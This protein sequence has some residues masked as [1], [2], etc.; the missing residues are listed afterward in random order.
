MEI[1]PSFHGWNFQL[2]A[3]FFFKAI[4]FL[5]AIFIGVAFLGFKINRKFGKHTGNGSGKREALGLRF[6]AWKDTVQN[7]FCGGIMG[8]FESGGLCFVLGGGVDSGNQPY[9]LGGKQ[10]IQL[11]SA[12]VHKILSSDHPIWTSIAWWNG[13]LKRDRGR[14][15]KQNK[16][17]PDEDLH[18]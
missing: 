5:N 17:L 10:K 9:F 4:I 7:Q 14:A 2:E 15:M 8:M 13:L 1:F 16:T 6:R 18:L 3:A 11:R 12:C